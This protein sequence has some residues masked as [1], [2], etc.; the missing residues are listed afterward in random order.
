MSD[1]P[2]VKNIVDLVNDP[3]HVTASPR[4][5]MRTS[6]EDPPKYSQS[7]DLE[8][9]PVGESHLW[10]PLSTDIMGAAVA[11]P[12][13][14]CKGAK[15][16]PVLGLT[17]CVH[18]NELSGIACIHSLVRQIDCQQLE[19]SVVAV[20][21]VNVPGFYAGIREFSDGKDL[22]RIFPGDDTT[23]SGIYASN[24]IT[25][26][27]SKFTH[28]CDI[29]TAS[30]GKINTL[31]VKADMSD[32]IIAKMALIFS[33]RIIVNSAGTSFD[34]STGTLRKTASGL[35]IKA[36]TVEIGNPDSLNLQLVNEALR[37][38]HRLVSEMGM[39]D[40]HEL[41]ENAQADKQPVVCVKSG[42]VRAITGGLLL[43]KPT[44]LQIVAKGDIIAVQTNI[45]GE[46][47]HTYV[48]P[49]S[50]I[51]IGKS[52]SPLCETGDRIIHLGVR[53]S[54]DGLGIDEEDLEDVDLC[55][56]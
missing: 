28:L 23:R 18:G 4:L 7:L 50:G 32:P 19:G 44:L 16:G 55:A 8:S 12:V 33:P 17:A 10:I 21:V 56:C 47:V 36:L 26:I 5:Q 45:F 41:P 52:V 25:K 3:T 15:P 48:A 2:P 24:L 43:V 34:G 9:L 53:T 39:S 22:N 14:V 54:L 29:H 51:V 20:L 1:K 40:E 13:V 46:T 11:V 6:M 31:Y 27:V 30:V 42:W 35:G 37:G 38:L 49:F